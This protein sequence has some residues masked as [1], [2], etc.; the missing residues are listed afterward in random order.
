MSHN[1][2][3]WNSHS[4][5]W[6]WTAGKDRRSPEGGKARQVGGRPA[7]ACQK[8][9]GQHDQREMAM[10]AIPAAALVMVQATLAFG[11]FVEL[12]NRPAAMRHLHQ[13]L[14]RRV[15]WEVTVIPLHLTALARQGTLAEQPTLW[16]GG[17]PM[18]AGGQLCTPCG[19]MHPYGR[20]LF[21]EDGIRS[22]APGD[23]LPALGGQGI[24][25]GFGLIERR[26]TRLVRLAA[27]PRTGRGHTAWPRAPRRAGGPQRCCSPPRR[28]GAAGRRGRAGRSGYRHSQRR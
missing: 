28:S 15:R 22:S 27:P 10:Q 17:D 3:S 16:P 7:L 25:D 20:K 9:I 24:E 11:I 6:R 8:A 4:N 18:M 2:T 13:A 12:L 21:P 5:T 26:G 1:T 19:P 23:R 14:Q